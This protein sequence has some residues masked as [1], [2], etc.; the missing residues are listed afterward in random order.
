MALYGALAENVRNNERLDRG[1]VVFTGAGTKVVTCNAPMRTVKFVVV[2]P[3]AAGNG[4]V[5]ASVN[6]VG[7]GGGNS[8]VQFTIGASAACTV[9][10]LAI[11]VL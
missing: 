7:T 8:A 11:G 4:T 5:T 2:T 9:Y 1:S 6:N 10:W 3:S